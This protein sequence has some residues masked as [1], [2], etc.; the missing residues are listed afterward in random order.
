MEL[1]D[2][3]FRSELEAAV[4][5][6]EKA[7][8]IIDKYS[9]DGFQDSKKDDGSFVTEAD[10]KSQKEIVSTI[11]KEFPEDSFL[12]E[13]EHLT[14]E[15]EER[16]WIIDPIDGTFNFRRDFE[17]HCVSIALE[18][19][20]E[21]KV[22]VV[23]CPESS[24]DRT[25]IAVKNDGSYILDR[26]ERLDEASAIE[27]S[28]HESIADSV[29]FATMF[30]IYEGELNHEQKVVEEISSKGGYHRQ[31]GACA[32]EMCFV[33]SGKADILYNPIAKKWDYSAAKLI[34]EEA[35]GE[36]R[37]NESRF[38]DTFEITASN[39]ELQRDIEIILDKIG[40]L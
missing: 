28:K 10:L 6:A 26:N 24:I 8:E 16:V 5:A 37:V 4:D 21:I 39:G 23:H 11:K 34:I 7:G 29:F 18:V 31:L 22:G 32:L 20:D 9:R 38:S 40:G 12:G 30:D 35:G 25:Y 36:V 2:S 14:P 3:E 19:D 17:Y 1:Q 13:E 27:T 15:D 33:A